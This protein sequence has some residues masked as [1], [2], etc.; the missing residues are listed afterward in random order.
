[1]SRRRY[2]IEGRTVFI[3]GAARG[4]GAATAQRLHAAGANV[5]LVGLEPERLDGLAELLGDSAISVEADVT[6]VAALDVAVRR[7][8][9]EFGGIDVAIANAG[10]AYVGTLASAP[11]EQVD[12]TLA[13]NLLGV[14]HTDRAVLP[15]VVARKGY[16]LNV[17]SLAAA[18][19]APRVSGMVD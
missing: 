4:I 13:V 14:W 8:V 17:A 10:I 18:V 12:R 15:Y 9:D 5:A 1:L 11:T 6:D 2:E 3:T 19:R 7:T 16:L